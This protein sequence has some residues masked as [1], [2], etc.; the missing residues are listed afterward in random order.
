[1][2]VENWLKENLKNLEVVEG[3]V[4]EVELEVTND[5]EVIRGLIK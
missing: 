2:N 5:L 4:Y 3:R 1:M